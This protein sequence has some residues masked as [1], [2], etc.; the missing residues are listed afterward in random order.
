MISLPSRLEHVTKISSF[1]L[2]YKN[3][4]LTFFGHFLGDFFKRESGLI[5]LFSLKN[6]SFHETLI[7]TPSGCM[8]L[9][10]HSDYPWLLAAGFCNGSV[11][12]YNLRHRFK[13]DENFMLK[14]VSGK[15][16]DPVWQVKWQKDDVDCN[17][18]FCSISSDGRV[19]VWTIKKISLV[20]EDIVILANHDD[21]TKYEN[22]DDMS[23]SDLFG[24]LLRSYKLI[25]RY[26]NFLFLLKRLWNLL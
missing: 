8:C 13:R 23:L 7:E 5:L 9:D 24:N 21:I 3:S 12:V 15:H 19:K 17:L 2:L 4:K 14:P 22:P 1:K 20:H 25:F 10:F 26:F 16:S 11:C 6:P 18:N